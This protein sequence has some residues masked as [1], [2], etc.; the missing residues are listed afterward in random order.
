MD[1]FILA[2][3]VAAGTFALNHFEQRKR[4]ALLG[5]YLS[6]YQIEKL[7][8]TLTQGYLRAL[9]ESDTERREQIWSLLR[10]T[11]TQLSG[12]FS[13]FATHFAKAEAADTLVSKIAVAIPYAD[14]LFPGAAFDL[15]KALS[16]HADGIERAAQDKPGQSAKDKA[17]TM[18]AEL[19]LMQHTCHWF[20]KSKT[21]ASARMLARHQTS[22]AQLVAAVAPATRQAYCAL[23]DR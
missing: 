14:K 13:R 5:S 6:Q 20:C 17:F 16:I 7:M 3:L 22:Y 18:S 8:E 2:I 11:E 12:Q 4:I 21:I 23:V 9:G 15:R 19:L 1:F 10:T